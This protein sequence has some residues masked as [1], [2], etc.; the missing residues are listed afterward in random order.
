[1]LR[2]EEVLFENNRKFSQVVLQAT[3]K[4]QLAVVDD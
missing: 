2:G 1:M 3:E 4:K